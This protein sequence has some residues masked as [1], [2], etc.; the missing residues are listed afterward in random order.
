MPKAD[1]S[2][3]WFHSDM[4]GAPTLRGEPGAL[5]ELLDA[6]LINGFDP[7]TPDSIT[8]AGEVATVTLS[9]GNPYDKHAVVAITGASLAGLN[10]EW[11][12][13][14]STATTF[15][16]ACPGVA[17]G[18]ATGAASKRAGAGWSKPYADTNVSA[19]QSISLFST[20]MYLRIDDADPRYARVRGYERMTDIDVGVDPFPTLA[21]RAATDY[22]WPKSD[23]VSAAPR[24]WIVCADESM[25]Y[26]VVKH[27]EYEPFGHSLFWFGDLVPYFQDDVFYCAISADAS[28][29]PPYP[30]HSSAAGAYNA[31][32]SEYM[33]RRR[34][35]LTKSALVARIGF[36]SGQGHV[37]G[38]DTLP[39]LEIG[40]P[41]N[42]LYPICVPDSGIN[43][44]PTVPLRGEM[45]GLVAPLHNKPVAHLS[46]ASG[47]GALAGKQLLGAAVGANGAAGCLLFDIVGPWR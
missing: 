5:I 16:F 19:Y 3:K 36:D 15:T 40:Q 38:G 33:A 2:V 7:R 14:T 22:T 18:A 6:C 12:I 8:V 28:A 1:T 13:A 30:G 41:M 24:P 31:T 20:R 17:D 46:V 23:A 21:Q 11:R 32:V 39:P 47:S 45:P 37:F 35:Q 26:L 43:L 27:D 44:A 9:G 10:A 4:P 29:S 25:I 34:D 42:L